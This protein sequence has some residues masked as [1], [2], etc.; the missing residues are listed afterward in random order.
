MAHLDEQFVYSVPWQVESVNLPKPKAN[1]QSVKAPA[2]FEYR[3]IRLLPVEV[4]VK[5]QVDRAGLNQNEFAVNECP[6]LSR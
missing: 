6:V 4:S 3:V 1:R 5:A 2:Y